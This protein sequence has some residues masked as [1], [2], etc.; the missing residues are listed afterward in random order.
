MLSRALRPPL[1]RGYHQVALPLSG[2]HRPSS[3]N[4]GRI[5]G[6][7]NVFSGGFPRLL[8][9]HGPDRWSGRTPDAR[10]P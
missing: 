4:P 10:R 2:E 7:I 3:C 9:K 1:N 8:P 6:Q 5:A